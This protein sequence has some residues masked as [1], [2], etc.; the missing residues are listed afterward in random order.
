MRD[1]LLNGESFYSL[2]EAQVLIEMW[3][4]HY[5]T[6]RPHSALGYRP[7]GTSCSPGSTFS[8]PMG[9]TI[10]R[11]GTY[12]GGRSR[13]YR[14][15]VLD[16]YLFHSLDEGRRITVEWLDEYNSIRPHA[17]LGNKTPYEFSSN[18]ESVSL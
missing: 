9:W 18:L 12:C 6:I 7:P 5:N 1:E 8:N 14:E 13:T 4:N 17:S 15:D 11:T 2:K 16:A 10:I 3:R